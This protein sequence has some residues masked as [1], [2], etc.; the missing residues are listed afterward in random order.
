MG[1]ERGAADLMVGLLG[2]VETGPAGGAMS[3]VAQPRLRVLLTLA[4]A[5][6]TPLSRRFL[7]G[8]LAG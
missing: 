5:W 3:P 8:L 4:H 7:A 6:K 1:G 2:P